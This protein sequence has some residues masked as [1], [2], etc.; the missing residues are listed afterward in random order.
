MCIRPTAP[1][2]H[3]GGLYPSP[4]FPSRRSNGGGGFPAVRSSSKNNPFLPSS[5]PTRCGRRGG[6]G[7]GSKAVIEMMMTTMMIMVVVGRRKIMIERGAD[8]ER[9]RGVNLS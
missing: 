9:S 5:Q 1:T 7:A 4:N 6:P 3:S 8:E 2:S